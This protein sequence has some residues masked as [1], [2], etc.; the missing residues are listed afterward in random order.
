MA[1]ESGVRSER[2]ILAGAA[3]TVREFIQALASA[4]GRRAP[5]LSLPAWA[6]TA[7]VA[8]AW[9]TTPLT[10]WRPPVTVAGVRGGGTIYDGGKASRD[11][12]V[13][14]TPIDI[15]LVNTIRRQADR[16]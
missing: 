3:V 8:A 6:V 15:G 2:Y 13:E 5:R 12:G 9:A 4:S 11:L 7:G 1:L 10:R 14:Y 16:K